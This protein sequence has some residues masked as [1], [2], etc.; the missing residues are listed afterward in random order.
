MTEYSII[1][2]L[3]VSFAPSLLNNGNDPHRIVTLG[4]LF[5]PSLLGNDYNDPHQIATLEQ[6]M[7]LAVTMYCITAPAWQIPC[8]RNTSL[9]SVRKHD[10]APLSNAAC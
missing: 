4:Q 7:R 3:R 6:P 8:F 2:T 5:S 10:P 9:P 1:V